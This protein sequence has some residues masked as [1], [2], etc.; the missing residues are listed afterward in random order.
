MG[1]FSV[2]GLDHV[3]V[4][5]SDRETAAAW[6]ARVLGLR[7]AEQFRPWADDPRGPLF[8]ENATGMSC[9]AL[10]QGKRGSGG[11]HTTAFRTDA[12]GFARFVA[13]LAEDDIKATNG[14][15]LTCDAVVDHEAAL[16]IYFRDRD[17]NRFELTNYDHATARDLLRAEQGLKP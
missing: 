12:G 4:R 9:L 3:H 17:D 10:F 5:V 7:V 13:R 1:G 14:N 11:D 6:F 8:L 15:R 16:S 2:D